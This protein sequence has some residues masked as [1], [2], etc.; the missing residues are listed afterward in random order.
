MKDTAQIIR[1]LREDRDLRQSDIASILSISQQYYSKYETGQ[2]ELPLRHIITLSKFY[3]ISSDYLLGLIDY[4]SE[5]QNTDKNTP[6]KQLIND[7]SELN[8]KSKNMLID[9]VELLKTKE[10][11]EQINI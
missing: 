6:M 10:K 11:Y 1:E 9:Y 7:I 4:S 3:N 5:I 8:N 2:Y